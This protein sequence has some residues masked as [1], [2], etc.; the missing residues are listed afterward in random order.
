[1][2]NRT[3]QAGLAAVELAKPVQEPARPV[4]LC[5]SEPN[6]FQIEF[7]DVFSHRKLG[8]HDLEMFSIGIRPPL[9]YIREDHVD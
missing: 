3:G 8:D 9:L 1:M 7:L 4:C 2:H 5:E 6:T